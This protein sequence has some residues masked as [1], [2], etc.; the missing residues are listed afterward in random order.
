[1]S[2]PVLLMLHREGHFL[3]VQQSLLQIDAHTTNIH[4]H[5]RSLEAKTM[6][7][8]VACIPTASFSHRWVIHQW[9]VRWV[10]GDG[11]M[12]TR[13]AGIIVYWGPP[14]VEYQKQFLRNVIYQS[15]SK[16]GIG[17]MMCW[18]CNLHYK[19]RESGWYTASWESSGVKILVRASSSNQSEEGM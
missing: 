15:Q 12:R 10:I 1:M 3:R 7:V 17:M 9:W 5:M 18:A 11:G 6:Q 8:T 16:E 14:L 4:M 19:R 2:M 13:D